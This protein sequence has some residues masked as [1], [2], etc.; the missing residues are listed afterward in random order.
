MTGGYDLLVHAAFDAD[1]EALQFLVHELEVAADIASVQAGHVLKQLVPSGAR[2]LSAAP[3]PLSGPEAALRTFALRAA[4]LRSMG[5]V[6]DLAGI[7]AT[8]GFG[9]QAAAV[10][11]REKTAASETGYVGGHGLPAGFLRQIRERYKAYDDRIGIR[12]HVVDTRLHVYVEDTTTDPILA[13]LHDIFEQAGIRSALYL[14][15]LHSE[16]RIGTLAFYT[17][18]TRRYD[19]NE[20]VLAQVLADQLAI[21][22][23]RSRAR[24]AEGADALP[25]PVPGSVAHATGP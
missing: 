15:L 6:A 5:E 19:D 21:A 16:H 22:M 4:D 12:L 10:Y 11:L 2:G 1:A 17:T 24:T 8:R 20:I 9:V 14:P 25:S 18:S 23:A 3:P 7:T 13:G